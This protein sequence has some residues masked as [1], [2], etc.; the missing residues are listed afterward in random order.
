MLKNLQKNFFVAKTTSRFLALKSMDQKLDQF[1][2]AKMTPKGPPETRQPVW[3]K[4][5][6]GIFGE[7]GLMGDH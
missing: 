3:T 2:C 1:F 4:N 7:I 5:Q 6:G